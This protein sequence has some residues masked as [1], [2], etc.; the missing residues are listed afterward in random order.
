ML[1]NPTGAFRK[2]SG[3]SGGSVTLPS[4]TGVANSQITTLTAGSA[5][6]YPR[7]LVITNNLA[8]LFSSSSLTHSPV[9]GISLE[10]ASINTAIR[11]QVSG[12]V[13]Y[14]GWGLT[15]GL[16]YYANDLGIIS[17]SP[18]TS[19]TVQVI[20]IATAADSL[21]LHPMQSIRSI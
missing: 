9:V 20:G 18:P 5:I 1:S 2:K 10:S 11:V 19:G 3:S 13:A 21:L 4:G 17:A 15:P 12:I 16:S 8:Q 6:G 14:G 7:A